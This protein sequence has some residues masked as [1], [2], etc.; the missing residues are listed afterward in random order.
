M[1]K[2]PVTFIPASQLAPADPNYPDG[3]AQD[4]TIPGDNTGTPFLAD[5][6]NDLWGWMQALLDDAE[7]VPDGINESVA[8]SQYLG[9]VKVVSYA[10][11]K[12]RVKDTLNWSN[13]R[14]IGTPLTLTLPTNAFTYL[15]PL[16]RGAIVESDDNNDE[17]R[18]YRRVNDDWVLE[19]TPLS[20][21]GG[22]HGI[23]RLRDNYVVYYDT[24][25]VIIR[26]WDG[27]NWSGILASLNTGATARGVVAAIN[28]TD[29]AF[30]DRNLGDLRMFRWDEPGGT[31][32]QIGNTLALGALLT[33]NI[34][35]LDSNHIVLHD[36]SLGANGELRVYAWDGTDFVQV[37]NSLAVSE[38]LDVRLAIAALTTQD[39]AY[40]GVGTD[41]IRT[42]RWDG[43]DF[44]QGP[45]ATV[46]TAAHPSL[47]AYQG[48]DIAIL[49]PTIDEIRAYRFDWYLN[50][51]PSLG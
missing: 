5:W 33:P 31:I 14:E 16:E 7:I 25:N 51:V 24:Q 34:C 27:S 8:S 44:I 15:A 30:L 21:G 50:E 17:L 23:A 4:V 10:Q 26:S 29:F 45:G 13:A 28:G 49:S 40:W 3:K 18:V 11:A 47:C 36:S 42:Y 32:S 35:K 9:A 1:A 2:R 43:T 46:A 41:S 39:I 37:G 22:G 48:A 12:Q 6:L 38:G 19:G 20:L